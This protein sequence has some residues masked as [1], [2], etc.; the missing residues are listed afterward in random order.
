MDFIVNCFETFVTNT[1]FIYYSLIIAGVWAVMCWSIDNLKSVIQ[2]IQSIL[3]PYFQPN[4]NKSLVEK[5]GK[6]A[7]KGIGLHL[8][9]IHDRIWFI[10]K[11]HQTV[12]QYI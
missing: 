2:I 8:L 7:G 9:L 6:W 5:F 11:P 4:E 10:L 3:T 1:K 12:Q